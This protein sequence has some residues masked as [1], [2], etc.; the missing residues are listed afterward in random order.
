MY[1]TTKSDILLHIC[2]SGVC[3]AV[4]GTFLFFAVGATIRQHMVMHTTCEYANL[5]FINGGIYANNIMDIRFNGTWYRDIPSWPTPKTIIYPCT[6]DVCHPAIQNKPQA[7][8]PF[9]FGNTRTAEMFSQEDTII[10][11]SLWWWYLLA[12]VFLLPE[13]LLV[14]VGLFSFIEFI[15]R[16]IDTY[17]KKLKH[18]IQIDPIID[19][20]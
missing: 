7:C 13:F 2:L 4:G 16:Y 1:T 14:I 12:F 6:V 3:I 11:S 17:K 8:P 18:Y 10:T 9:P 19:L 20:V 15:A 5:R